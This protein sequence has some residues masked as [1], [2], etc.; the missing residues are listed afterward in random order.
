MSSAAIDRS[1]APRRFDS[2]L[3]PIVAGDLEVRLARDEADLDAAQ[4][5]RYRV[6]YEE[7][8][9]RPTPEMQAQQRDFDDFD[10]LCD[11]LLV[12]DRRRAGAASIV[13]TYR[14]IRRSAAAACGRFYSA[15]EYDIS[16]LVNWPGEVLELGRSCV[17][18]SARNMST[19]N[20]LWR[21]I[22]TFI[23]HFD[24]EVMFGC[25]SLP[26]ND[27]QRLALPLSYLC[28]KHLAPPELRARALPER[29]VDMNLLPAGSYDAKLAERM[30]PPLIKGYLRLGGFVGDGAV[31]D[32]QFNT[33]DVCVV[34][35]TD[36]VT[37][38]YFRHYERA[39]RDSE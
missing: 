4:A 6:F 2:S 35:K 14:L 5:L 17:D 8:A 26:G 19:M 1:P 20:M 38:K 7:M 36:L 25:A 3:P 24:I 34:V 15:A 11:H 10:A 12:V 33:V 37:E 16:R 22:A 32:T 29:Y 31:I 39:Q 23:S 13:G 30:V 21:G 28:H 9:A 18:A 27:L